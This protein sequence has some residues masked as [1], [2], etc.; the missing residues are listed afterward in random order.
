MP[1][2]N[3]TSQ[4]RS[5]SSPSAYDS[6]AAD[7][8]TWLQWNSIRNELVNRVEHGHE[9]FSSLVL[10]KGSIHP[11]FTIGISFRPVTPPHVLGVVDALGQLHKS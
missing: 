5:Q 10:L 9:T 3:A 6:Q 11:R 7:L 2:G 1:P 8:V 4:P